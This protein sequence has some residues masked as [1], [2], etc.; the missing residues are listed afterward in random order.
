MRCGGINSLGGQ[1]QDVQVPPSTGNAHRR[2]TLSNRTPIA[3]RP[4]R[5]LGAAAQGLDP[6]RN[7]MR[8]PRRPWTVSVSPKS[9]VM[10]HHATAG[11]MH[12]EHGCI[13]QQGH[14]K[15]CTGI[16]NE[17]IGIVEAAQR[18]YAHRAA[19]PSGVAAAHPCVQYGKNTHW[20]CLDHE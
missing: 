16:L 15:P 5:I 20:A 13:A 3:A 7:V 2:P 11:Q 19:S 6:T 17:S 12:S 8:S 18:V 9:Q 1:H 4:E 10:V 14:C